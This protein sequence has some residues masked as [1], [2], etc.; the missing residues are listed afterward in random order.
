MIFFYKSEQKAQFL[1][2]LRVSTLVLIE[3]QVA[4]KMLSS[5]IPHEVMVDILSRLPVSSL[6]RFKSVCK[7]W[8]AL[9]A[10]NAKFI[11]EHLQQ[12]QSSGKDS[13]FLIKHVLRPNYISYNNICVF[14]LHYYFFENGCIKCIQLDHLP[15]L[16]HLN[17]NLKI[18]LTGP[19]CHGIV[20][21]TYWAN[22]PHV[23]LWNPSINGVRSFKALPSTPSPRGP[24]GFCS[25]GAGTVG[26]GFD[27]KINDYKCVRLWTFYQ[28]QGGPQCVNKV[29]VCRVSDDSWREIENVPTITIKAPFGLRPLY[30]KGKCY[31]E[32]KLSKSQIL[33]SFDFSNEV[34]KVIE[35]PNAK[36]V[37]AKSKMWRNI[38]VLNDSIALISHPLKVNDKCFEVWLMNDELDSNSQTPWSKFITV[39]MPHSNMCP[40]TVFGNG[41]VVLQDNNRVL[42]LY[43][44]VTRAI[45]NLGIEF[46]RFDELVVYSES[47]I[48]FK[49]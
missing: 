37:G 43:N 20:C 49:D 23:Y 17:Q 11:S 10:T 39:E 15:F 41:N 38:V 36:F 14:S 33:V 19:Q 26:F 5:H 24:P 34:F 22:P 8:Y 13:A 30:A 35:L 45:K 4:A 1:K 12:S 44:S 16:K 29:E 31:W 21:F 46:E 48:S 47:L 32:I 42:Q 25:S 40:V 27:P 6:I 3:D 9:I 28:L 7:S 18:L 2:L